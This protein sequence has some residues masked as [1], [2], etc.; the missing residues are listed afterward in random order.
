MLLMGIVRL[1]MLEPCTYRLYPMHPL[2]KRSFNFTSLFKSSSKVF[3][4]LPWIIWAYVFRGF[5]AAFSERILLV[6]SGVNACSYCS[7]FH[8]HIALRSG[9]TSTEVKQLL[10][11]LIPQGVNEKEITALLFALHYAQSGGQPLEAEIQWLR[12]DYSATEV[13][14]IQGLCAAI[15]FGNLCGNTFDAFISRLKGKPARGSVLWVELPVFLLCAP[16]LLPLISRV[17][18]TNFQQG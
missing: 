8:G 7:W 12:D 17:K 3:K 14:G 13:K 15:Q 10:N 1:G 16:F 11:Q 4:F 6:I 9:V 18:N 2:S 5:S